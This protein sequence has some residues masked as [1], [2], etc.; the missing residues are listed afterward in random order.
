MSTETM[1]RCPTPLASQTTTLAYKRGETIQASL[2]EFIRGLGYQCLAE[3]STNALGIAP[4]FGVMT[5][6]GENWIPVISVVTGIVAVAYT[7]MGGLRAVVVTDLLQFLLLF[8]GLIVSVAVVSIALD[9]F[10]WIPTQWDGQPNPKGRKRSSYRW[11][12]RNQSRTLHR[13][14]FFHRR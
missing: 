9:G 2:Q 3:S 4:A 14:L 1:R 12:K 11:V 7:S 5:G 10:S 6:L 13:F 8:V